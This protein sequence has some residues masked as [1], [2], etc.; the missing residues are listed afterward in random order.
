MDVRRAYQAIFVTALG[1]IY[2]LALMPVTDIPAPSSWDKANHALA[3]F[4]LA[5]LMH[6]AWPDNALL[7]RR[8]VG[9]LL[10]GL[11]IEL[12][13]LLLSWRDGSWEDMV[14]NAV[15]LLLYLV[16]RYGL[17]RWRKPAPL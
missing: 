3:F 10:Y 1:I 16:F 6:K 14:A 11:F 8:L 9:L 12:S 5:L 17:G 13:Q 2:L 4:V 7:W 15:G